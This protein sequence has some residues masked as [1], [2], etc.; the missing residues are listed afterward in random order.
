MRILIGNDHA[1]TELKF[2]IMKHLEEQGY[3]V[4]NYGTDTKESVNYPEIGAKVAEELAAGKGDLGVLICGT[5][6]GI[7]MA[8]NK[9][10]G[11]RAA[12]CSDTTTAHLIR[13]HN[14]ANIIGIGAR[15]VGVELAKD[16]VDSFLN[17]EP[18]GGRHQERVDMITAIENKY[19]R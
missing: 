11:I 10:P 15:I 12:A 1:G 2:E 5:G 17:A 19:S 3:E 13:E 4:E 6:V 9:V 18:L 8:A 7:T 14:H 16:I